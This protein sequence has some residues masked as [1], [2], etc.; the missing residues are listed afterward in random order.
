M[1]LLENLVLL[2]QKLL[3]LLLNVPSEGTV[4]QNPLRP[5]RQENPGAIIIRVF[6]WG[7]GVWEIKFPAQDHTVIS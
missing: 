4:T 3:C 6:A 1:C 2:R 5:Q 7:T